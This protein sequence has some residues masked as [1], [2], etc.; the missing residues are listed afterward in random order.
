MSEKRGTERTAADWHWRGAGGKWEMCN[1]SADLQLWR[2]CEMTRCCANE[3][4]RLDSPGLYE[5]AI[6]LLPQWNSAC[7]CSTQ[8][9]TTDVKSDYFSRLQICCATISQELTGAVL[10]H[11]R[12]CR[13]SFGP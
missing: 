5:V 3:V 8:Q 4:G 7:Q 10:K 13:L 12:L 1:H 2:Q 9:K 6:R 11:P